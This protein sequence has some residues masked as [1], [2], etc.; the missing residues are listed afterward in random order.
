[1]TVNIFGLLAVA[2]AA[3]SQPAVGKA[4]SRPIAYVPFVSARVHYHAVQADV[5]SGL[6]DPRTAYAERLVSPWRLIQDNQPTV[7]VNGTFFAP[8]NGIPVADVLVD[9]VLEA[10]GNRGSVLAVDGDGTVHITDRGFK[11]KFDWDGFRYGMRGGVRILTKGKVMPNPRAQAFKDPRIWG[12]AAR[13]AVGITKHGKLLIVATRHNV[14]LTQLAK[15][16]KS[17]GVVDAV[18]L[19]GGGST[20]MYYRGKMV[21]AT[22]RRL[23]NLFTLHERDVV[24]QR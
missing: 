3:S 2:A 18:S 20:C 19:D 14:T 15:A 22:G 8:Q 9:G 16:M 13:T 12:R 17:R 23:S 4:A 21:V 7:A 1:L 6:V 5:N 10:R 11:R 24:A